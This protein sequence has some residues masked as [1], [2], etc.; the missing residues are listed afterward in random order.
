MS[1]EV[2][3]AGHSWRNIAE[4]AYKAYAASTGGK[5]FRGE[6]MPEFADLPRPIQIAWESAS[7]QVGDCLASSRT[8]VPD[9]SRWG[10]WL[11]PGETA[12]ART[13][14][15]HLY[16]RGGRHPCGVEDCPA[17]DQAS[18]VYSHSECVFNYCPEPAHCK[19]LSSGCQHVAPK[20]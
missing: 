20:S 15:G 5:N 12:Y 9:E 10:T 18:E 6:P 16:E 13:P 11:P 8:R 17:R 19:S 7:R 1:E 3:E 2:A 14:S 4:S